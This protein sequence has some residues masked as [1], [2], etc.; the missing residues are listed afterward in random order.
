MFL[1]RLTMKGFKSFADQ[2]ILEFEPGVTAVVGPNGSGKSNVVDAVTWVLGAQSTR[3][4]RSAKMDDVIFAGTAH[5]AALGRA[6]VSLTLDNT[7]G[8][9][10]IDGAEV[11]ISRTLFRNGDSEYAIN[12]TTCRLLDVQ[13]LLS[14]SGVG[15]QQ[16]MIIGQGQLDSILNSS[17]E[18]RRAVIEEAAGVLK[19][20]RRKERAERRLAVTQE[21]L[22]RLGDLVREVRRQM[23]PLER[24]AVSAR[25]FAEVERDL[26]VARQALFSQ[27]LAAF[28][29]RRHDLEAAILASSE[30]ERELRL[31]LVTLDAQAST[32]AAE[33]AS[34]REEMLASTLGTLQ[35]LAERARGTLSVIAERERSLHAALVASADENVIATLEA[36][37]AKLAA[38]LLVVD[39]DEATLRELRDALHAA[40]SLFATAQAQHDEDFANVSIEGDQNAWRTASERVTLLERTLAAA[41]ANERRSR[42]RLADASSQVESAAAALARAEAARETAA[43][44]AEGA[45]ARLELAQSDAARVEAERRA[46]DEDWEQASDVAARAQARAE[47]LGRAL[48][49][50]SGS[51]GRAIISELDGV[52]GAFVDLI[53]VDDGWERAVESAAGASVGA[54]VV[55]GRASA[56]AA[57]EALRREGG[58]GLILPVVENELTPVGAPSNCVALRTLVRARSTAPAHVTRVLDA[59]FSRAYVAPSWREGID[60]AVAHPDLVV[61][62]RD[63][64]RFA[65]SG[66]R[67]ASGRALVT[68]ASV[69]EAQRVALEAA[70]ALEPSR[71]RR[72]QAA[73]AVEESRQRLNA[74]TSARASAQAERERRER[75]IAR[76]VQQVAEGE[77]RHAALVSEV[78]TVAAECEVLEN[79]LGELR[80]AL[81]DLERAARDATSRRAQADESRARVESLRREAQDA[82]TV[83]SRREAEFAERRRL[84]EQRR[85]EIESRLEGR[86]LERA[87]AAERRE[88]LEFDLQVLGRLRTIVAQAAEDIRFAQEA[89]DSTYREQLEASRAGAERLEAVRRARQGTDERLADVAERAHRG[90]IELAELAVKVTNLHEAIRRDLGVEPHEVGVVDPSGLAEGVDLEAHV[91]E[92]EARMTSL[93]PINPLALE[94]LA[95]LEERYQDL[96]AQVADVR[97]ARRELQEV[98]R[99]LDEEI[100]QTFSLAVADVNEHFSTLIAMLF[101]GGQ[102]RLILTE[103]DDPLNTGVEIEVR[104]MGRNVRRISLL[105]GGERS[106]AAL[107]FL[108]AV[109]RS[110]PSPFYMMDEVEAALD[111][112]NLQRF[113]SLVDE[114][115]DEAQLLIVTHQKRTMES[116]DALYGVTMVPGAS[117]KVVSQRVKKSP[118]EVSA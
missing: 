80:R 8:K 115:R 83:L 112:V 29:Q 88:S 116:A 64:D 101:P 66:W 110:R 95:A 45:A 91:G 17:S 58:A 61:V 36:D 94:E 32:A 106:M 47:A 72:A 11:T 40:E 85:A 55:D 117:S 7:S 62:T 39:A 26:R 54:M 41:N 99:A 70:S 13:E 16:H 81:P 68:R 114:F 118:E 22:E 52:L 109:F 87:Q 51:G 57:L 59:L 98:V 113:L 74:A 34:R 18:N 92:L 60:V 46:A 2:T 73:R 67:V 77:S 105:S 97:H 38:D 3:A 103:P 65:A 84:I 75:E 23:R 10:G 24:Q 90:Q 28:D 108:F 89:M 78:E 9:L 102:G 35:G 76:L 100:M 42:Q 43:S 5:K 104:P 82:G 14:D 31:E 44:E 37:A 63:G 27:R 21:N 93:G 69:E 53:E 56:Q 20:R 33:M 25:T 107:A 49:E 79:E 71:E 48:E 1:K 6:E 4:L 50:L 15:R 86:S 30:L 12:S 111:D 19:H 96:D